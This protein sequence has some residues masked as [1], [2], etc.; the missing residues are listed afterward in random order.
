MEKVADFLYDL[1]KDHSLV[2]D[3]AHYVLCIL[4][5]RADMGDGFLDE[6]RKHPLV[7]MRRTATYYSPTTTGTP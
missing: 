5:E 4:G 2:F 7:S 1:A 6:A 3:A